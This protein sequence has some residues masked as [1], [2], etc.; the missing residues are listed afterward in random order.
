MNYLSSLVKTKRTFGIGIALLIILGALV[1]SGQFSQAQTL[2]T[3]LYLPLTVRNHPYKTIFGLQVNGIS[4]NQ[5]M[6]LAVDAKSTFAGGAL[7]QWANVEPTQGARNWPTGLESRL[8]KAA[9][10]GIDVIV[11]VRSTPD[12]A[13]RDVDDNSDPSCGAIKAEYFDEFGQFMADLVARYSKAPYNVKYWEIWNEPDVDPGLLLDKSASAI[14]CWGDASDTAGYGGSYYGEMLKVVYPMMKQADPRANVLVG[15]LLLDCDPRTAGLCSDASKELPPKFLSGIL[16]ADGGNGAA[17]FDG[18]SFHGYDFNAG[19]VTR[20]SNGGWGTSLENGGP[21]VIAKTNY[22]KEIL[23]AYPNKLLLNT[24]GAVICRNNCGADYEATKEAYVTQSFA[25]AIHAGLKANLWFSVT[26]WYNSGLVDS[27][28]N[29]LPGYD[30]YVF[31]RQMMGNATSE[32]MISSGDVNVSDITKLT[33]YKLNEGSRQVWVI[34]AKD[35]KTHT[36]SLLSTPKNVYDNY[37]NP[38]GAI[39]EIP[40]GFKPVYIEW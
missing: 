25:A 40:V 28:L 23:A 21:V 11:N 26:G 5:G 29:P 35:D 13:E 14:G 6:A 22:V 4:D 7:I 34:W 36:V 31:A 38:L 32:G 15:G 20:Y 27:S 39:T 12:W 9:A 37:G 24:E 8:A 10:N 33:G 1:G 3:K 16:A 18:V 30:A 19:A 17:Y 2:E